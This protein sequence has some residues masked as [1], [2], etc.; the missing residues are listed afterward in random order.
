MKTGVPSGYKVSRKIPG[1]PEDEA[2][3]LPTR[4]GVIMFV[5]SK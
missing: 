3:E 4:F 5:V 1:S 2:G